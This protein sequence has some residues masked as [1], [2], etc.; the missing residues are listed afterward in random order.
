M[1]IVRKQANGVNGRSGAIDDAGLDDSG[2]GAGGHKLV[3]I[4]KV[5]DSSDYERAVQLLAL[6]VGERPAIRGKRDREV[7][8]YLW[9]ESW[10]MLADADFI[11]PLRLLE[12]QNSLVQLF[13]IMGSMRMLSPTACS[14]GVNA[15]SSV[16]EYRFK[17]LA[18]DTEEDHLTVTLTNRMYDGRVQSFN[19]P[20]TFH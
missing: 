10:H 18:M 11:A 2:S 4:K 15:V 7:L 13:R 1:A 20:D 8:L 17:T 5:R 16:S 19:T 9:D 6:L 3:S 14:R 12:L